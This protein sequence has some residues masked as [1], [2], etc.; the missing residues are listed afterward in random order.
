MGTLLERTRRLRRRGTL[1]LARR[2][3][4]RRR[5]AVEYHC[6]QKV[7]AYACSQGL[8][9]AWQ[10]H[11]ELRAH[12][13]IG[14]LPRSREVEGDGLVSASSPASFEPF[15]GW[16]GR[17]QYTEDASVTMLRDRFWPSKLWNRTFDQFHLLIVTRRGRR[18]SNNAYDDVLWSFG[19]LKPIYVRIFV[20]LVSACPSR[21]THKETCGKA[22]TRNETLQ[23]LVHLP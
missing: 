18:K 21:N 1:R 15:S 2:R 6:G 11:S 20:N 23:L 4:R 9:V 8:L 10:L 22:E 12:G 13:N 19:S 16:T 5:V 14:S 3:R 7:H 17:K